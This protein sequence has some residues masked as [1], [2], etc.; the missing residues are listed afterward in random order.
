MKLPYR[1]LSFA[2]GL[3]ACGLSVAPLTAAPEPPRAESAALIK[4]LTD[5]KR[6]DQKLVAM[7]DRSAAATVA[8]ISTKGMGTGSGVIVDSSGTILSAAHVLSALAGDIIV[9]FPDGKRAM[10]KALGADFTRDAAMLQITDPGEYP[11][12]ELA[13]PESPPINSWCVA[14]GHPGGFDPLRTPPLRLGRV[15]YCAEFLITDCAVVGG[16]SGGPLFDT[17]GRVIGIHSNIGS[18]LSENR[19]VPIKVFRDQWDDLLAGKRSGTRF[20]QQVKPPVAPAPP[21]SALG[22]KLGKESPDGLTIEEVVKDSRAAKAGLLAGDVIVKVAG[23][24]VT[25]AKE[26]AEALAKPSRRP[27]LM[28]IYRRDGEEKRARIPAPAPAQPEGEQPEQPGQNDKPDDKLIQELR[29]RAKANGGRLQVTPEE[30]AKLGGVRKL[31]KL[32]D[33]PAVS[34]D[35]FQSVLAALKPVA[36]PASA[37]TATVLADGKEVALGTVVSADGG[38]LTKD[39]ETTKGVVSVGIGGKTYPATL[40][41]RFAE[42]DLAL[43]HIEADQLHAVDLSAADQAPARGS[44]LAVPGPA[45]EPLGIG[46]VSVNSRPLGKIGFLGVQTETGEKSVGGALAR[47]V[48]KDGPAAKAGLKE[49]DLIISLN[50]Q[51]V[52]NSIAFTQ[53]VVKLKVDETVKLGVLRDGAKQELEIKLGERPMPA[54]GGDFL[55]MNRMSGPLSPKVNGFPLALQHDIPLE[56]T[57]CGGPLIDLEGRCIGINVARAGRVNSLAIPA[58]KIAGLLAGVYS[59]HAGKTAAPAPA[60]P[61]VTAEDIARLNRSLEEIQR[62]LKAIEKRLDAADARRTEP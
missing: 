55:K 16:D 9:L 23:M 33:L 36:A 19:H 28:L 30:V 26:F 7:A 40:V 49:G 8:L 57:Q 17:D 56:P 31:A 22:L 45:A 48:L 25:T 44:L 5:L 58:G 62:S 11:Y 51:L 42:W 27:N 61:A 6:L 47:V 34:D 39:S 21:P 18:G 60:A 53:A 24:E 13:D 54:M 38:I 50:G 12:A 14:L 41:R 3:L 35:F 32:L 46:L 59:E 43:F 20:D 52:P 2:A 10:A 29:E 1:T 37:F 15:L 4:D